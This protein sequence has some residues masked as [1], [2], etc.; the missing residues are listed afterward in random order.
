MAGGD[1]SS[2]EGNDVLPLTE[3]LAS[4]RA[5]QYSQYAARDG[6]T[7]ASNDAFAEMKTYILQRYANIDV[8]RV[9]YYVVDAAGSVFDCLPQADSTN[10]PPTPP[11]PP[12]DVVVGERRAWPNLITSCPPGTIPVQRVTL[13]TLLN[14]PDLRHFFQK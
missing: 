12:G 7:I 4:V 14:F 6:A 13:E 3:F 10:P 8:H 11:R 9:K 1:L 2:R 5:A